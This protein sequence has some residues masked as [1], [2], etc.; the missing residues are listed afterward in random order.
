MLRVRQL[1]AIKRP[2]RVLVFRCQLILTAPLFNVVRRPRPAPRLE[3][4]MSKPVAPEI[5]KIHPSSIREMMTLLSILLNFMR[6][7]CELLMRKEKIW[8]EL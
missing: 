1:G 4:A 6:Q 5:A 8:F 2:E 7:E 3:P